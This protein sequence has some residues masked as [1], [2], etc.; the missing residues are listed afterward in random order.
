LGGIRD[1]AEGG[2]M[3]RTIKGKP[4]ARGVAGQ[5]RSLIRTAGIMTRQLEARV[6]A[7][8]YETDERDIKQLTALATACARLSE[9]EESPRERT[10]PDAAST[11]TGNVPQQILDALGA[12]VDGRAAGIAREAQ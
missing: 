7:D 9:L 5:A 2:V 4:A 8:G 12:L 10:S 6:K 3:A 1:V 11:R